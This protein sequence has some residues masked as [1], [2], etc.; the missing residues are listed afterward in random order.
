MDK[1]GYCHYLLRLSRN[2]HLIS[3]TKLLRV[4]V[5]RICESFYTACDSDLKRTIAVANVENARGAALLPPD[6]GWCVEASGGAWKLPVSTQAPDDVQDLDRNRHRSGDI[7]RESEVQQARRRGQYD[8]GQELGVPDCQVANT[9]N[10]LLK[11]V[12]T[13]GRERP[14][15]EEPDEQHP[16]L[17]R[18]HSSLLLRGG[19]LGEGMDYERFLVVRQPNRSGRIHLHLDALSAGVGI[20]PLKEL[21]DCDNVSYGTIG[22]EDRS[23]HLGRWGGLGNLRNPDDLIG[24]AADHA[25]PR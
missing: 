24:R 17:G 13:P 7:G 15:W 2:L 1:W 6:E 18:L 23:H 5:S 20:V 11:D 16:P 21:T 12:A 10:C 8:K 25:S 22:S 3:C 14:A 9:G 19:F 4:V